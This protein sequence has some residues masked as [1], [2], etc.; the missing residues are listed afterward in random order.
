MEIVWRNKEQGFSHKSGLLISLCVGD[1]AE[2]YR[3]VS[4]EYHA[5]V[6][7]DVCVD[8]WAHQHVCSASK[9]SVLEEMTLELVP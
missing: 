2:K 1:I 7:R 4:T 9:E 8:V 3:S 6:A 5:C